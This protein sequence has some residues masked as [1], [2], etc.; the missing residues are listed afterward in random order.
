MKIYKKYLKR[1]LGN[2]G[3]YHE[4]GNILTETSMMNSS[5]SEWK[6]I[7][8]HIGR[9]KGARDHT[10]LENMKV[11]QYFWYKN[12]EEEMAITK[13]RKVNSNQFRDGLA[14]HYKKIRFNF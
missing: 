4:G 6:G 3:R 13:A 2:K 1:D 7:F 14:S 10:M 11:A 5:S 12:R 8:D 9:L